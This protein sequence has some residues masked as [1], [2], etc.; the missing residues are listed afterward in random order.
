MKALKKFIYAWI[1]K[2][3]LHGC[4]SYNPLEVRRSCRSKEQA[5]AIFAAHGIP[6]ARGDIFFSP[7]RAWRFGKKHG[8]PLVIKPN[9]SGFSRGS[10][11]PINSFPELWKAALMVKIW[12]PWSVVEE[13]LQGRNY[14][15]LVGNGEII[16]V[17]RRYPPFVSG[18]GRSSI[19]QLIDRENDIREKMG[20]YPVI[21]PIPKNRTIRRYLGKQGL[22]LD[23]I[24]QQG[25]E[26]ILFNRISLAPG[27]VVET[28]SLEDIPAENQALFLHILKLFRANILGIDVIMEEGIEK[29][30]KEQRCIFLEVNSRPFTAMHDVPR[31]GP[32]QDLSEAFAR[33]DALPVDDQDIF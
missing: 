10:H 11:F 4:S 20:L 16:S 5:R 15:I 23:S 22:S 30:W 21:H 31:Y 32:K 2:W 12:W 28:L 18:D 6:H 8:F 1:D 29:S 25:Q 3:F 9:V 33:L 26:V 27:G 14:R 24:P 17:I 19:S 7:W 13:Y